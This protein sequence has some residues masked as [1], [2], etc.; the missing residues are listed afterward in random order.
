MSSENELSPSHLTERDV[1]QTSLKAAEKFD[2][3]RVS[4]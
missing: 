4:R 2:F 3:H 1:W